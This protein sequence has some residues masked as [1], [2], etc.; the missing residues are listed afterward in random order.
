M[1]SET[2]IFDRRTLL[3]SLGPATL[4]QPVMPRRA[5]VRHRSERDQEREGSSRINDFCPWARKG[6]G[7]AGDNPFRENGSEA[8]FWKDAASLEMEMRWQ[9][10]APRSQPVLPHSSPHMAD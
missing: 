9:S 5:V 10:L 1:S 6:A 7:N 4:S 3:R 8:Y 2:G